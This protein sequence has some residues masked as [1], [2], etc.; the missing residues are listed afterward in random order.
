M[1]PFF[2]FS[3]TVSF[4]LLFII[5]ISAIGQSSVI[6]EDTR[7]RPDFHFTPK[8][9]WMND[10]N[11]LVLLNGTYHLFY[12][13]NPFAS[14][15]GPM[16]WGHTTS[17]DLMTW[18]QQPIALFP[19]SL[20]TI[21]SGSIVVDHKNTSGFGK[22]GQ[23]PLIA[24]YTYHN[25]ILADKGRDDFQTQGLAFSLD[26][27]KTWVKYTDNPVLINPGIRDFRDP[28]VFWHEES[29]KWVMTLAVLD[30]IH[31]YA[32]GDLKKWTKLSEFGQSEGVHT[33]VWEC[34]DLFPLKYDGKT[35]WI[36]IVNIGN[37]GP[38]KGSAT[39]YF[40]GDFDGKEFSSLDKKIRWMDFGPDEYAGV[41]FS[42]T[43]EKRIFLGWMSNWR[44]A[45]KVPTETW[46][47]AMTIARELK[48]RN[49]DGIPYVYSV[50]YAVNSG[51]R[52]L[53]RKS[54]TRSISS[55]D[56]FN[57]ILMNE[58]GEELKIGY[59]AIERCFFID[60]SKSGN[61]SFHYE[62]SELIK[63]KRIAI[64]KKI[65]LKIIIDKTSIELFADDGLTVL[66][67]IYFPRQEYE[68]SFNKR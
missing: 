9:G 64:D 11:G 30:R 31:F 4:S 13:H 7:L 32:S 52:M 15:W 45:N 41:T 66:T 18:E 54:I 1:K 67:A 3:I 47:S 61:T 19:D 56:D 65:D 57:M 68:L 29:K 28:K 53:N 48:L 22:N 24:I 17:K 42:N 43:G 20:G 37:G 62:F 5:Q 34:P 8:N 6:N 35:L 16:H 60:R 38:N 25:Q 26:E 40:I 50:P 46:R 55:E 59:N 10:P 58:L 39:Q 12:Q 36:L 21:F 2:S 44:Y 27:G 63:A 49:V 33:G 51:R 23:I 14:V